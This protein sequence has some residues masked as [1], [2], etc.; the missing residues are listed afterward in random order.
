MGRRWAAL[1]SPLWSGRLQ[2]MTIEMSNQ[3][4]YGK[5]VGRSALTSMVWEDSIESSIEPAIGGGGLWVNT[6]GGGGVC[7][8]RRKGRG[9]TWPL[10]RGYL[11]T[12]PGRAFSNFRRLSAGISSRLMP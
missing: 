10:P 11:R 5:A 8:V 6:G 12:C 3:R 4:T 2:T 7:D 1:L 9:L